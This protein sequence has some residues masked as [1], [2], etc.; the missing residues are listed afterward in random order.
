[1]H[2]VGTVLLQGLYFVTSPIVCSSQDVKFQ[3]KQKA[4]FQTLRV[5]GIMWRRAPLPSQSIS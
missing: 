3:T 4:V 5:S 1:M 2:A